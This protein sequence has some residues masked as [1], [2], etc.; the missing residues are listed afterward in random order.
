MPCNHLFHGDCILP[1]LELHNS[2]PVCRFELPVD[3]DDREAESM[4]SD[5]SEHGVVEDVWWWKLL[6]DEGV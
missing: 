4:S 1:W 5:D 2:C 6:A 3:D